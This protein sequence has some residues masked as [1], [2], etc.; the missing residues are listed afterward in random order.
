MPVGDGLIQ[1]L[2]DLQSTHR[3]QVTVE[4]DE[5]MIVPEAGIDVG[6]H[7]VATFD[8][9]NQAS[10]SASGVTH[11]EVYERRTE[12][13]ERIVLEELKELA[14]IGFITKTWRGVDGRPVKVE[15]LRPSG[16]RLT[17][18]RQGLSRPSSGPTTDVH[19]PYP[20]R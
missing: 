7:L 15:V 20:V 1:G 11:F 3:C 13:L 9:A 12:D 18:W 14:S 5:I 6:P 8:H 17:T 4:E 10:I 19:A 16:E 2:L